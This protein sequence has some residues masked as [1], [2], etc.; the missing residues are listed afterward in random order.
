M[1][2]FSSFRKDIDEKS[3]LTNGRRVFN[4]DLI[5]EFNYE[6]DEDN[7]NFG[8][9][10]MKCSATIISES[11]HSKYY[12]PKLT[13]ENDVID[14]YSCHCAYYRKRGG[15]ICK[16]LIGMLFYIDFH[17]LY[18]N[19]EN[20]IK[21]K[22]QDVLTQNE[23]VDATLNLDKVFKEIECQICL[24]VL[25]K[26]IMMPCSMH[27]VC[28]ECCEKLFSTNKIMKK[29]KE[30]G[31]PTCSTSAGVFKIS[32]IKELL[33][34]KELE[35][36]IQA[37][38]AERNIWF[39]EKNQL[40]KEINDLKANQNNKENENSILEEKNQEEMKDSMKN[41]KEFEKTK[42]K[43]KRKLEKNELKAEREGLRKKIIQKKK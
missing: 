25:Q 7:K 37:Y 13:I 18:V 41:G 43:N 38:R 22:K 24:E 29:I 27:S 2:N 21:N 35:R 30:I 40:I 8:D 12:H 6:F 31:C 33:I 1:I 4:G 23:I 34:N 11:D 9:N 10:P 15:L 28:V 39:D 5:E 3:I 17:D 14:E 36:V 20:Q 16:H 42:V 19:P 26:P 32:N